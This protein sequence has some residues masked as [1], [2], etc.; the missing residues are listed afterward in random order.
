MLK[1]KA[2]EQAVS[3]IPVVFTYKAWNNLVVGNNPPA[4]SLVT[5]STMNLIEAPFTNS[6]SNKWTIVRSQNGGPSDTSIF[7]KA[8]REAQISTF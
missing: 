1:Y 6:T 3:D 2:T 5:S 8:L 7:Y 4:E